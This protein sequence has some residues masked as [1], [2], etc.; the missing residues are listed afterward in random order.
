MKINGITTNGTPA[1][2]RP[3]ARPSA[4]RPTGGGEAEV[5]LSSASADLGAE[6]TVNTARVQEIRQAVLEGRFAINSSAI[7]DRLIETARELV[8]AQ[9]RG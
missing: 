2:S 1:P 4:A 7:A 6:P 8:A 5:R 3:A 9:R